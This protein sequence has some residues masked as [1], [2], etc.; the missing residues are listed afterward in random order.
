[1]ITVAGRKELVRSMI[2]SLPVY[3]ITVIKPPK[4]FLQEI[5]KL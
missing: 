2:I 4:K 5:D 3:L 1:M